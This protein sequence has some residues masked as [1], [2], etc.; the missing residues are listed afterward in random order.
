M[1]YHICCMFRHCGRLVV[2]FVIVIVC[3]VV[4]CMQL[5]FLTCLFRV[6][7]AFPAH[8]SCFVGVFTGFHRC[9]SIPDLLELHY[10]LPK[11]LFVPED[12]GVDHLHYV[13]I[14]H[15]IPFTHPVPKGSF[16]CLHRPWIGTH[17]PLVGIQKSHEYDTESYDLHVL[18]EHIGTSCFC[19]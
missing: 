7:K 8:H 11:G 19:P 17:Q 3:F 15:R 9:F 16:P 13:L 4:L 10:D 12:V 14:D 6:I 18:L 1:L 5:S 2:H